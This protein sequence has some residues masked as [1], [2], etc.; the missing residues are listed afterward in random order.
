MGRCL[1]LAWA[2]GQE[3]EP[4]ALIPPK[5]KLRPYDAFGLPYA[6]VNLEVFPLAGSQISS[7]GSLLRLILRNTSVYGN[8]HYAFPFTSST[9]NTAPGSVDSSWYGYDV[10]LRLPLFATPSIVVAADVAYLSEFF[11]FDDKDG[12]DLEGIGIEVPGVDYKVIRAGLLFRGKGE[13]LTG[14]VGGYYH[15]VNSVGPVE[16][17]L[18][19]E[20]AMGLSAIAGVGFIFK[21]FLEFRLDGKYTRYILEFD[22]DNGQLAQEQRAEGGTDQIFGL[23]LSA[24]YRY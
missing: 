19:K 11:D 13:R 2:L 6:T 22:F 1:P 10:G 7:P 16:D 4:F 9:G 21:D 20:S 14:Q 5:G 15:L 18:G 24:V 23:S 3:D 12:N 17:R 8:G